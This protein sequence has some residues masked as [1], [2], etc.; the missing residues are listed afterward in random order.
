MKNNYLIVGKNNHEYISNVIDEKNFNQII[1]SNSSNYKDLSLVIFSYEISLDEVTNEIKKINKLKKS[2]LI[3]IPKKFDDVF[4]NSIH[5]INYYPIK[6]SSFEEMLEILVFNSFYIGDIVVEGNY[7]INKQ[8]NKKIY[9]TETQI[10]ILKLLISLGSVE[11]EK[12][13]KDIL[14][15]NS[16]LDTKSLESHLSRIRKKLLEINSKITIT[17]TENKNIQLL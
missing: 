11:K 3:L 7:V 14:N 1:F 8:V 12:L 17:S 9:F 13:K 5:K 10:N 6:I 2:L 16:I 15:I 4:I